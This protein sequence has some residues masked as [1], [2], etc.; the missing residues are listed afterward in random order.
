[1]TIHLSDRS[2][3]SPHYPKL[4]HEYMGPGS[5][6]CW[7]EHIILYVM[8]ISTL[9]N[10]MYIVYNL[11]CFYEVANYAL[12]AHEPIIHAL[13]G[14]D[15]D[16]KK[17]KNSISLGLGHTYV[18]MHE[19]IHIIRFML[20]FVLLASYHLST[21]WLFSVSNYLIS[22]KNPRIKFYWNYTLLRLSLDLKW[23]V[24]L[25]FKDIKNYL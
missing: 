18:C 3:F 23:L 13:H 16:L 5:V 10:W 4:M 25:E 15:D 6:W 24:Q 22:W 12:C 17:K 11:R 7:R 20:F 9:R 21:F 19:C 2:P 8:T 14:I 1:M